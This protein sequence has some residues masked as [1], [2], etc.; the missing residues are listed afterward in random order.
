[1]QRDFLVYRVLAEDSSA[2]RNNPLLLTGYFQPVLQGSL[3]RRSPYVHPLYA[4]S[5]S[6]VQ[7]RDNRGRSSIGRQHQGRLLP[8]L[9]PQ[10]QTRACADQSRHD[11]SPRPPAPLCHRAGQRCGDQGAAPALDLFCG[12]GKEA[13]LW[14]A[15]CE[16]P[17]SSISS[18]PRTDR[19][20]TN[21][22]WGLD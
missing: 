9:R 18:C 4:V 19:R 3:Q 7:R 14:Q 20:T 12:T 15:G 6:L 2:S 8:A 16:R 5:K 13:V 21:R 10:Y 22:D 11:R 17:A 1:M